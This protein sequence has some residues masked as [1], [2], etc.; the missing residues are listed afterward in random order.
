MGAYTNNK[1]GEVP[2][3]SNWQKN[4]GIVSVISAISPKVGSTDKMVQYN[5]SV[6]KGVWNYLGSIKSVDHLNV[7]QMTQNRYALENQYFDLAQM[8]YN[9]PKQ[10]NIFSCN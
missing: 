7:V 1:L 6:Q 8:L 3:D 9:L 10:I 4:D 2:I 5:N